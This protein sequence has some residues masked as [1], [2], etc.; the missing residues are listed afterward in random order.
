MHCAQMLSC[1]AS[2]FEHNDGLNDIGAWIMPNNADEGALEP[3]DS[4]SASKRKCI[5]AARKGFDRSNSVGPS[6]KIQGVQKPKWPLGWQAEPDHG[7]WQAVNLACWM[8]G[9]AVSGLEDVAGKVF[10]AV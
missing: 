2:F 7:L 3:L 8:S 10:P 6:S 1:V 5:D 9:S 4:T